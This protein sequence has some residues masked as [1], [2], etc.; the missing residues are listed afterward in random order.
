MKK[1]YILP[2]V[3]CLVLFSAFSQP[4]RNVCN[5]SGPPLDDVTLSKNS[6][7][8]SATHSL[9]AYLQSTKSALGQS[10]ARYYLRNITGYNSAS[11]YYQLFTK[12]GLAERTISLGITFYDS[13]L[14]TQAER[15]AGYIFILGHELTHHI[16]GDSGVDDEIE[17][18]NMSNELL[19]DERGGYA[20]G[21]MTN[22]D[23]SFF[24]NVLPKILTTKENTI[25]HPGLKWRILA[26]K[27]G[28][29]NAKS[30]N[31]KNDLTY[32]LNG[33]GY[34]KTLNSAGTIQIGEYSGDNFN[35]I[36]EMIFKDGDIF[37]G[38]VKN[39]S[40]EGSGF[41]IYKDG[42]PYF[43]AIYLG[44]WVNNNKEGYNCYYYWISGQKFVG[45]FSRDA[46]NGI[47]TSY[48]GKSTIGI[49]E[50]C[51]GNFVNGFLEGRGA[52]YYTNGARYEGEFKAGNFEGQGTYF[53]KDGSKYIG[54]WKNDK[55]HGNGVLFNA[56]TVIKEGCW[57]DG[58]Y[59]GK[60]CN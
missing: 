22:E 39:G 12:S 4:K 50:R 6:I 21:K 32:N 56:S 45:R 44:G 48:F 38:N 42:S 15:K 3:S 52:Y 26:A 54:E 57:R 29:L 41:R 34:Q 49:R 24:D 33:R 30:E 47:G 1:L 40:I 14:T 16:N 17:F 19:A 59:V 7:P 28:W 9:V 11:A 10:D 5:V 13:K 51:E 18:N 43:D 25:Y 23:I 31:W 35:G 46:M 27:A 37:I 55:R 58:A 20:V 2:F 8:I 53:Y 60:T 36:H